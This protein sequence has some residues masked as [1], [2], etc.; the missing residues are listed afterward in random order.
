MELPLL[1]AMKNETG[2]SNPA[3]GLLHPA[4]PLSLN[5]KSVYRG[6]QQAG[7]QC[8]SLEILCFIYPRSINAR[9]GQ[10]SLQSWGGRLTEWSAASH[11]S[12]RCLLNLS[13]FWGAHP[14]AGNTTQV[15]KCQ[16]H[17]SR[18]FQWHHFVGVLVCFVVG[19]FFFLFLFPLSWNMVSKSV[20]S[21]LKDILGEWGHLDFP[22]RKNKWFHSSGNPFSLCDTPPIA[23][24]DYHISM[25]HQDVPS[26]WGQASVRMRG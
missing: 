13:T 24:Y 17:K 18:A 9:R 12:I 16:G 3:E 19:F 6:A 21:S 15:C 7:H 2:C 14:P 20:H 10:E 5:W 23:M 26:G 25:Y 22:V 4:G 11:W 8:T 1:V